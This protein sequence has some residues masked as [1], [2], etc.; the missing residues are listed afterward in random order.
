MEAHAVARCAPFD[1]ILFGNAVKPKFTLRY[2]SVVRM[3]QVLDVD[4]DRAVVQVF[5][6]TSGIDTRSTVLE[7]TGD[8]RVLCRITQRT[9][10]PL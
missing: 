5:E 3:S 9:A 7:F 4:G 1:T 2:L 8:V 6:G 10:I